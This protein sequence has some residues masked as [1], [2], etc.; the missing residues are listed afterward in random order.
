MSDKDGSLSPHPPSLVEGI[1]TITSVRD[2]ILLGTRSG[3]VITV[4][5][6]ADS[7]SI[8]CE[9]L[10]TTTADVRC[11]YRAGATDP[12]VLVSCDNNLVSIHVDPHTGRRGDS[13]ELK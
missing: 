5:D 10:G 1:E 3:E 7:V 2:T 6:T 4:K 8:H 9:K 12:T 13:V 11:S